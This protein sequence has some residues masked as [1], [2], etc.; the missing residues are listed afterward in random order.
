MTLTVMGVTHLN[1]KLYAVYSHSNKIAVFL[2]E[3][4]FTVQTPIVVR[5][6]FG[7]LDVAA[8]SVNIC[9]YIPDCSGVWRVKIDMEEV[10]R[11]EGYI[12]VWL[13]VNNVKSIWMV[14][15][16][17]VLLTEFKRIAMYDKSGKVI[18][19][20]PLVDDFKKGVQHAMETLDKT[21]IVC[22]F[23]KRDAKYQRLTE[24]NQCGEVL[25]TYSGKVGKSLFGPRYVVQDA[26]RDWLFVS[27]FEHR[28]LL[29]NIK[30]AFQ[31]VLVKD[32]VDNFKRICYVKELR[33]LLLCTACGVVDVYRV[34]PKHLC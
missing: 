10:D 20:I 29:F 6:M 16:G 25:Y 1:N 19:Q 18:Y 9:C 7:P 34:L 23:D 5:E 11:R 8:C 13:R 14:P 32:K 24:I 15:G 28:V 4:P 22:Q 31:G 2:A 30:M 21:L 3:T 33:L 12:M 17:N 26:E 27:Y